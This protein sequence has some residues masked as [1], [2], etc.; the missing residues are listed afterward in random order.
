VEKQES[1]K[2]TD[3]EIIENIKQ[4]IWANCNSRCGGG[5]GCDD[6]AD[7]VEDRWNELLDRW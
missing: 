1:V 2:M 5:C 6:F 3:K 7:L 4:V